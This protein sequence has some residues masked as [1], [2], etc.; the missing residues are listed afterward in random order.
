MYY[1]DYAATTPM[2]EEA[3]ATYSY[4]AQHVYG[5]TASLHDAGEEAKNIVERARVLIAN[6]LQVNKDGLIFTGSG[7]EGNILGIVALAKTTPKKHIITT[8]AEHTSVHAA[9]NILVQQGYKVTK[10]KLKEDGSVC[11]DGLKAAITKDTALISI[12][13][14]NSE[15]GAI[16]PIEAIAT[17]AIAHGILFHTDCVQSF[18]KLPITVAADAITISAHKVG[19]PKGCGALYINPKL[20]ISSL[21]PG[22]THERGLRGGT[23]DTP[24]IAAFASAVQAYQYEITH[25]QTLRKQLQQHLTNCELIT[26]KAQLPSICGIVS[27]TLEGQY[28]LLAANQQG[29]AIS[30]GSACDIFSEDGTKAV[31]AMGYNQLTARRFFRVSMGSST[32]L[33]SVNA[34]GE[35]LK[36]VAL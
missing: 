24:A 15:T 20:V 13:H 32:T 26:C 31:Q 11:L 8:M 3:L 36:K 22:V 30:T 23:L 34:L 6:R 12:Q 29:F 5:N 21:T 16:Q 9:M 25:Y 2:T 10:L 27:K 4:V 7:T 19:G 35:M 14:V 17:I 33:A 1:F 28:I 18:C